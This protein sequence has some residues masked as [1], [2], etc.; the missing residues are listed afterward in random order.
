MKNWRIQLGQIAVISIALLSAPYLS[1]QEAEVV[2]SFAARYSDP[3]GDGEEGDFGDFDITG[4]KLY[5][6]GKKS[7]AVTISMKDPIA[8]KT[9][10]S[11]TWYGFYLDM[12]RN[13]DSGLEMSGSG[14]DVVFALET[15]GREENS[16][17]D[18][19]VSEISDFARKID[20]EIESF[21]IDGKEINLKISSDG[22]AEYPV[23]VVG[24]WSHRDGVF[25]DHIDE[26]EATPVALFGSIDPQ[27]R[28]PFTV[29]K[30]YDVEG[31]KYSSKRLPIDD[32]TT[33]VIFHVTVHKANLDERFISVVSLRLYD[34]NEDRRVEARV[35]SSVKRDNEAVITFYIDGE[36]DA[37]HYQGRPYPGAHEFKVVF[38]DDDEME[39]YIDDELTETHPRGFSIGDATLHISGTT[40]DVRVTI[41]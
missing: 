10:N 25:I 35:A 28:I 27:G 26:L 30:S 21:S 16:G 4:L 19:S 29:K 17:W 22:F 3:V 8:T 2:Q 1:G 18:A 5:S 14:M 9:D 20:F 7:L 37:P 33:E 12:D 15:T 13:P 40:A 39:F 38:N 36:R 23:P 6:D 11:R 41:R 34:E 24:V 32:E 31:G